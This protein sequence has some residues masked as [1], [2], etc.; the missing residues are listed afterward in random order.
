[1]ILKV[2]TGIHHEGKAE[3]VVKEPAWLN[4]SNLRK[5]CVEKEKISY[6]IEAEN[7][8]ITDVET[9]KQTT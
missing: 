6:D 3:S 8:S 5:K 9:N 1:M 4:C 7:K 2:N